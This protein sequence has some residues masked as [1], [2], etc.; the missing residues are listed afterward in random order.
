MSLKVLLAGRR[1][2]DVCLLSPSWSSGSWLEL[3]EQWFQHHAK[4]WLESSRMETGPLG[5][6]VLKLRLHPAAGEIS[7]LATSNLRMIVSAETSAVGPGYHIFVCDLFKALG[8]ALDIEWADANE[9]ERVGDPTGYFHTGDA[10]PVEVY[11]LAWL[12][13]SVGQVLRMRSRGAAGCAMSMRFGHVFEHP[14]ALLTP[15]GPRD[16]RWMRRVYEDPRLGI[17][18][19]PWWKQGEGAHARLG[20]ALC[21]LW[22]EVVWRPPLLDEERRLMRKVARTLEQAWRED[23]SLTYPW[24]E[25]R[26]VLGY[27]GV[28]G[29]LAEFVHQQAETHPA[30]GPSL[31]YRRGAVH[32]ALPEGWAIRIPGSLAEAHLEDGTWVARDHRRTVRFTPLEDGALPSMTEHPAMME[33]EHHGQRVSGRASLRKEAGECRLTAVC[34]SGP[35]RALCVVSFDD[36]EEEDWALGTWR[37]LDHASSAA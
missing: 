22:T 30:R 25:W 4:E 19:F 12:Q 18:V 21:R 27:L 2:G 15:L 29:T 1:G 6:P 11:M 26:E 13:E 8:Q 17:D 33:L 16:E 14:G 32:V 34:S 23:P 28:G 35:H 3:V 37:S 24:R 31:G 9:A 20:R 10:G 7:I 36:P 5:A